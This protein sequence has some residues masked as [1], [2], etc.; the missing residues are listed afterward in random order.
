MILSRRPCL[1]NAV[2]CLC[3]S[4]IPFALLAQQ[5]ATQ[6][7]PPAA[8]PQPRSQNPFE[9]VP[10]TAEPPKTPAPQAPQTPGRPV[11]EQPKTAEEPKPQA[12]EN[13]VEAI[14]FR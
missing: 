2:V 6:A 7:N 5:P 3:L 10:Q 14:E 13:I 11:L 12:I 4:S 8:A 1:A 9:T